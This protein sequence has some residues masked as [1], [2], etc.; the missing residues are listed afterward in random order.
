MIPE[1]ARSRDLI[2]YGPEP[3]AFAWPDGATVVV[4]LVVVYE[5]GSEAS[6]RWGDARNE[7]WGEYAGEGPQ[8]PSLDHGTEGH[9]DYGSRAGIWRLA[10]II[11]EAAVPAT[12]SAT[13][14]ALELNPAV[15]E[16]MNVGDHDLLGHGW[17]WLPPWSMDEATERE[18]L[19][20]AVATYER[21]CGRRPLG[22]NSP[23]SA[24][25]ATRRLL[26]EEGGFLYDSDPCADDVPYYVESAG[27]PLLVVPYSKTY[28]D[29]RY[30]ASPGF[31]SPRDHLD[32]LVMGLDE[33]V[34][35][36]RTAMMTVVVHAR[37]TGQA[38]RAAALRAFLEHA[39]RTPGVAFMRRDDIARW[40]LERH[41]PSAG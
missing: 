19:A 34:R 11:D 1:D 10:R 29:S 32:L 5:E 20:R 41:P 2:G 9:Y 31:G 4:N 33:L 3:P 39:G 6:M 7:G 22:W 25:D 30:L 24:S 18:H 36:G 23:Y 15:A 16:W 28:N 13:A 12:V 8:P 17:R 27:A 38:A 37:W 35:E 21:V 14:T 26:V 40:W